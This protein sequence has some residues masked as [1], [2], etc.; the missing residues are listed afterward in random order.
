[1]SNTYKPMPCCYL[2]DDGVQ[3]EN[4][5]EFTIYGGSHH[6]EDDS[7]ACESHVGPLLGTPAWWKGSWNVTWE[8]VAIVTGRCHGCGEVTTPTCLKLSNGEQDEWWHLTCAESALT[9]KGTVEG[10]NQ[11]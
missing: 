2:S 10:G 11:E 8:V 7:Q 3:C 1:M 9:K 6:P 4:N 5:A